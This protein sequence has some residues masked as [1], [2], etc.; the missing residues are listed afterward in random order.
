M[1][2]HATPK[3]ITQIM[4]IVAD[5]VLF[6]RNH[7]IPQWQNNYPNVTTFMQDIT[8]RTLYVEETDGIITGMANIAT[9]RDPQYDKIYEGAWLTNSPYAVVH[10]IAV[11]GSALGHGVACKLLTFAEEVAKEHNLTSIR[12]DTHRANSPMNHLL[13]KMG[14][15]YCGVIELTDHNQ[16]DYY[17]LAYAKKI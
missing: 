10:R 1:I 15:E 6:L 11:R 5:A 4:E 12:I 17:R 9:T 3:D 8:N 16:A 13:L 2:R 14:Y 7:N